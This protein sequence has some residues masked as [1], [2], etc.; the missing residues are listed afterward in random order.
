MPGDIFCPDCGGLVGADPQDL[1]RR[2]SCDLSDVGGNVATAGRDSFG[3]KDSSSDT[4]LDTTATFEE[5]DKVCCQC[6]VSVNGKKRAKNSRGYWCYDC[7]KAER[8]REKAGD[9]GKVNCPSCGRRVLPAALVNV[10]GTRVCS[11]C[12]SERITP[13]ARARSGVE[14]A[15]A[16]THEKR[17]LILL[18]ASAVILLRII[19][20]SRHQL[21]PRL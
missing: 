8:A 19:I 4:T 6:G 9:A 2:C 20:L 15:A 3:L 18:I 12:K 16:D 7:F 10:N 1:R 11:L 5:P 21:L 14:S 13:L 17:K